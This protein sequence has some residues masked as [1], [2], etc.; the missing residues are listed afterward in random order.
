MYGIV[1]S[2]HW[3]DLGALLGIVGTVPSV[4]GGC[5]MAASWPECSPR[6]RCNLETP[7]KP[8]DSGAVAYV[9]RAAD[10]AETKTMRRYL[11]EFAATGEVKDWPTADEGGIYLNNT[12]AKVVHSLH[13]KRCAFWKQNG[14]GPEF[15]W[16]N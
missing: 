11:I 9:E 5:C 2:A 13:N 4:T 1:N 6:P 14:F 10:K 12:G 16:A 15:W 3:L 7:T 8:G